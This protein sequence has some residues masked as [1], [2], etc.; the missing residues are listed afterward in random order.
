MKKMMTI[1]LVLG[2]S[3]GCSGT[4]EK[5]QS[6]DNEAEY[7]CRYIDSYNYDNPVPYSEAVDE[8]Y[9]DDVL[10]AG[11]SRMGSVALYGRHENAHVEFVTSLNLMM[12]DIMPID[13]LSREPYVDGAGKSEETR[14]LMDVINDN[15]RNN[16]YLLFGINEIRN[17]S[18]DA[19]AAKFQEVLDVILAKNPHASVYIILAYHPDYI[20]G[21]PE[22]ALTI[23]LVDLNEHLI[24]LARNNHVYYLD[25]DNGLDDE[26]NTI[27]NEYVA[28]GLH[29]TPTGTHALEDYF[30][31]HVIRR[32]D[33]VQKVCQ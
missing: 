24:T 12:I 32:E 4:A 33:Y 21:L 26:D 10:F 1:L 18:F 15:E 30:A 19:F 22:P 20:S 13:D 6:A 17:P 25:L 11:D 2:L 14:T 31:T 27:R 29:V 23:Q 16:I 7:S 28:D 8:S 9:Y 5:E 3:C